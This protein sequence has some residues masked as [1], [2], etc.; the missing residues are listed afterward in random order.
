M[1]NKV[2]CY[3][4]GGLGHVARIKCED[5]GYLYCATQEPIGDDILNEI[6][7]PHIPSAAE[8]RASANA[9]DEQEP[10]DEAE[11]PDQMEAQFAAANLAEVND[12]GSEDPYAEE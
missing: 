1:N 11:D 3:K 9:V 7:Y 12:D 2:C 10:E 5:G 4:C 6:K 8:R